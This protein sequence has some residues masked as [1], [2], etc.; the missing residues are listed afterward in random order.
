MKRHVEEQRVIPLIA[1]GW[2]MNVK[3]VVVWIIGCFLFHENVMQELLPNCLK[4]AE[5]NYMSLL[6]YTYAIWVLSD[7][8]TL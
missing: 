1:F 6:Y 3:W 2:I 5:G 7:F 4:E 8:A